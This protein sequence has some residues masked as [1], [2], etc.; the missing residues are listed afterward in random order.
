MATKV[1][2]NFMWSDESVLLEDIQQSISSDMVKWASA[3]YDQ[4]DT[5]F[6]L[7]LNVSYPLTMSRA[8]KYALAKSDGVIPDL[9]PR[10]VFLADEKAELARLDTQTKA[11]DKELENLRKRRDLVSALID[12]LEKEQDDLNQAFE[13]STD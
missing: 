9:R 6:E 4:I 8:R 2:L 13:T 12:S 11:S 5:K 3:F 1:P 10:E 7:D